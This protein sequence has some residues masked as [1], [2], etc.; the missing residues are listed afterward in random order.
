VHP[1]E[2]LRYVARSSGAPQE[3]LVRETAGALAALGFDPPGLVTAC[4]RILERHPLSG[5]LWWLAG[6][7]LTAA[8]PDRAAWRA[9]DELDDDTTAIELAHA[10]PDDATVCVLG[11]PHVVG[12][13]LPR[14]GDVEV[15][16][17]DVLGEGTGLV[18]RLLGADVDAVEVP[19]AGLASAVTASDVLLVEAS[20]I[21]P[22]GCIAVAGSRPA[23]SVARH[24]G[25]HVWVVGGVGR[26]LPDAMW[27]A[28]CARLESSGDPWDLDD[29]L[30]PIDLVDLVVGPDGPVDPAEAVARTDCPVA[31]EL[32][33]SVE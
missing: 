18:R 12:D 1:I 29:E 25:V 24:A 8:D 31:P 13:A 19:L 16:V 9:A 28:L 14:R 3:L 33:R 5:P 30:V 17:V 26:V 20:A 7:V 27:R 15:L 23:A 11:W 21:G 4:R 6:R 32:L 2:R 10:V 22:S